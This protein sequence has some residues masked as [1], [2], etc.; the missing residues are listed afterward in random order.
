[1]AFD[2]DELVFVVWSN[3]QNAQGRPFETMTKQGSR[4]PVA[5]RLS[6]LKEKY[7]G[8]YPQSHLVFSEDDLR[9]WMNPPL[10][11]I[12]NRNSPLLIPV[13]YAKS[14]LAWNEYD[15]WE[16]DHPE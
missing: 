11:G 2:Q 6:Y 1:V 14:V 7:S 4:L 10:R 16:G 13:E 12:I 9:S 5:W 15:V 3:T 8:L